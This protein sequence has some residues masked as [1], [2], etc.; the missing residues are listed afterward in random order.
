MSIM[1]TYLLQLE[2]ARGGEHMH[3]ILLIQYVL[4]C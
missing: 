3:G 4:A 1:I 2:C